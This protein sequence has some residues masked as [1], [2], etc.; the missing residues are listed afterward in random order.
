MENDFCG[1]GTK[2]TEPNKAIWSVAYCIRT[3][4]SYQSSCI[5][6]EWLPL[7]LREF[8][9]THNW[10]EELKFYTDF[11]PSPRMLPQSQMMKTTFNNLFLLN[12]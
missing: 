10:S 6:P 5:L 1:G 12:H 3:F 2:A 4:A 9:L 7:L 8:S 11:F